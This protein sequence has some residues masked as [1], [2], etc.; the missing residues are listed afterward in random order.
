MGR[1]GPNGAGKSTLLKIVTGLIKPDS[2]NVV[3]NGYDL[4][5]DFEKAIESVGCI[6]D[7]MNFYEN[8]TALENL[9][10]TWGKKYPHA[11]KSWKTNWSELSNFFEFPL[12]IRKM[13]YT[14]NIIENL[15]GKIRKYTKTKMLF[16][17]DQSVIKAVFLALREITRK[18]TAPI[19][20]WNLVINQFINIFGERCKI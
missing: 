13:I 2:G 9:E 12:E 20:N 17:D 6:L 7:G 8:M 5:D 15:N 18:W 4:K 19:L 16:P 3:I 14:T 11:I 10:N 1:V